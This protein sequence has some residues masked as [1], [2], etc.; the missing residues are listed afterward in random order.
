MATRWLNPRERLVWVVTAVIIA[1]MR[2][3]RPLR[4]FL[5]AIVLFLLS[6]VG[7][8]AWGAPRLVEISPAPGMV[9]VPAGAAVELAFSRAMQQET[10][11]E[12]LEIQP[13]VAGSVSWQGNRL[14]FTPLLPWPPGTT[15]QVTLRSGSRTSHF[16]ILPLLQEHKTSFVI[17]QPRL[18]FLYPSY[19][20]ANIFYHNPLTGQIDPLTNVFS[21]VLDFDVS[22][23]GSWVYYSARNTQGGSD[24]YRISLSMKNVAQT[25]TPAPT[26]IQ[27]ETVLS[28]PQAQCSAV[29]LS[30]DGDFLAFERSELAASGQTAPTRVWIL[31]LAEPGEPSLAGNPDHQ[32]LLPSWSPKG[33]LTFYDTN[34]AAFVVIQPGVGERARFPNQT[35]QPGDWQPDGTVYAAAEILFLDPGGSSTLVD[36]ERLAD[37]HLLLYPLDGGQTQDLT[38]IEGIEDASPAFSPDGTYLAFGRKFLDLRQWTPG[39]QLWLRR[40]SDGEERPLTNDPLYN[41]YDFAWSPASDRLAFVRFNQSTLTQPP[42]VWTIDPQSGQATQIITAGYAPQWIP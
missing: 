37:S 24:L 28:C 17:R 18:A 33:L 30:P 15:V 9:D 6:L 32:T 20:P 23:D 13:Q 3:Q 1:V 2:R 40:L 16:P 29:D 7:V 5:L 21:G 41:H 25:G 34:D 4:L 12:R 38:L 11:I 14:V 36:L 22:P 35:G 19:G 26:F 10:V 8:V 42:E 27:P 39:R 31:P